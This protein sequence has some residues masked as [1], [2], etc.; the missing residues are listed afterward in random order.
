MG[1]SKN[2]VIESKT[3][4]LSS[5]GSFLCITEK[6]RKVLQEMWLGWSTVTWF[7][8]C[9]EVCRKDIDRR[10]FYTTMMEGSHSFIAQRWS[11]VNGR[12]LSR[13]E[14]GVGGRKGSIFTLEDIGGERGGFVWRRC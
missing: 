2:L 5:D 11:N 14:Y 12:F 7:A 1:S 10:D 3:F 13:E 9:F 6:G 4:F 8:H